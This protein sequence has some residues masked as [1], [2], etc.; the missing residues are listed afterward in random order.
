MISIFLPIRKNSKR[1]KNKNIRSLGKY[2]FGL[3]ELKILQLHKLLIKLKI[4]NQ[5]FFQVKEVV[6]STDNNKVKKFLKKF[7]WIKIHDRPR[8][9]AKDDCLDDL[10]KEIPKICSGKY[11]LWT[12]VT[13]PFFN[14]LDYYNFLKEYFKV[15]KK[16]SSAFSADVKSKFLLNH[17]HKWISHDYNKKKW[18]RTQ[19]LEKIYEANSAVFFSHIKNYLRNKDRLGRKPYPLISRKNYGFDVDAM[20]DFKIVKEILKNN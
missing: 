4:K 19:D 15:K 5:K 11:I 18:P 2:K 12:H 9:L 1:I 14:E 3:T 13:S 6:V 20:D 16:F 7:S 17:K 8:H 10:I